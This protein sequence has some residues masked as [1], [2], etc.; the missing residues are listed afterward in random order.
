MGANSLLGRHRTSNI[1]VSEEEGEKEPRLIHKQTGANPAT[2]NREFP[3]FQYTCSEEETPVDSTLHE[4]QHVSGI[5][6]ASRAQIVNGITVRSCASV[7]DDCGASEVRII[8]LCSVKPL[9]YIK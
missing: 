3:V 7:E 1:V 2:G 5:Q 8:T 6:Q 9:S 4:G